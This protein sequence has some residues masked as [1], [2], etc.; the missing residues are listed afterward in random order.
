MIYFLQTYLH[1]NFAFSRTNHHCR[2]DSHSTRPKDFHEVSEKFGLYWHL[3]SNLKYPSLPF[4]IL[5]V[6]I[7]L[8][9]EDRTADLNKQ[10]ENKEENMNG[11]RGIFK[12]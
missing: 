3:G 12:R 4:I 1:L 5:S 11:L 8:L 6:F 9:S 2:I 10:P 7:D